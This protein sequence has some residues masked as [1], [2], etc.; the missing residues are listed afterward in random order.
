MSEEMNESV[1]YDELSML[2]E[3]AKQLGISFSPNIGLAALKEKVNAVL[4]P[5]ADAPQDMSDPAVRAAKRKAG[6]ML[7]RCTIIPTDP[8]QLNL[9]GEIQQVAND[10]FTIRR[11]VQYNRVTHIEQALY[12]QLKGKQ[13]NHYYE[14]KDDKGQT[15]KAVRDVAAFNII[16]EQPLTPE[17]LESLARKQRNREMAEEDSQK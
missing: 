3:R 5:D 4:E 16:D 7:R 15:M 1:E 14:V 2:K 17:E 10:I 8:L 9:P 13:R 12:D 11:V 6:M